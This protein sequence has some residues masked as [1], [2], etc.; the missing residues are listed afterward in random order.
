MT[1]FC[2]LSLTLIKSDAYKEEW[3]DLVFQRI[4]RLLEHPH[5]ILVRSL[6]IQLLEHP[7]LIVKLIV[8]FYLTSVI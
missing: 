3:S 7:H 6:K 8:K 5:L 1:H 2:R 4:G